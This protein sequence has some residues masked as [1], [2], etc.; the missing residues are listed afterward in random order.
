MRVFVAAV[1][2]EETID[3]LDDWLGPMREKYAGLKWTKCRNLHLT[4]RYFGNI[5]E[6]RIA[7]I[8]RFISEWQTDDIMFVF[9]KSGTFGRRN[10]LPVIYWISGT[11][12]TGIYELADRI[13][14]IEDEKGKRAVRDIFPHLTVARQKRCLE[15]MELPN[16]PAISGEIAEVVIFNSTLTREGPVYKPIEKFRL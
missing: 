10:H 8:S 12:G 11:F 13:G 6:E 7:Q 14:R 5:K 1:F 16:P 2:P 3:E 4:L 15:R 9:D